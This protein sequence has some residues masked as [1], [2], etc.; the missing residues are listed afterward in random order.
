A[1]QPGGAGGDSSRRQTNNLPPVRTRPDP[2]TCPQCRTLNPPSSC[3]RRIAPLCFPTP[4]RDTS[5][6]REPPLAARPPTV[7]FS[8]CFSPTVSN[9]PSPRWHHPRRNAYGATCVLGSYG[10]PASVASSDSV[11]KRK[12]GSPHEPQSDLDDGGGVPD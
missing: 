10:P 12:G 2:M 3:R 11:G 5:V 9:L 8:G 4:E 1:R 7:P 6:G